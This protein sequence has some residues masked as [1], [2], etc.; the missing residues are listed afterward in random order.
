MCSQCYLTYSGTQLSVFHILYML[1]TFAFVITVNPLLTPAVTIAS[2]MSLTSK[3]SWTSKARTE[4]FRQL[5][6]T[7]SNQK[8]LAEWLINMYMYWIIAVKSCDTLKWVYT[9]CFSLKQVCLCVY[10]CTVCLVDF[11]HYWNYI[12]QAFRSAAFLYCR[13]I[14]GSSTN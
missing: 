3:T 11:V 5:G 10:T 9:T 7:A 6:L 12:L 8:R 1:C 13:A 2:D 4:E 14:F